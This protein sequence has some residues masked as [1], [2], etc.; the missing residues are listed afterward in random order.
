MF[1]SAIFTRFFFPF[2]LFSEMRPTSRGVSLVT[3]PYL[4]LSFLHIMILS[5][6][7][8][9]FTSDL[10]VLPVL[11]LFRCSRCHPLSSNGFED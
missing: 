2:F 6:R 3:F 5:S 4:F 9:V 8:F 1:F 10:L 7:F 11:L